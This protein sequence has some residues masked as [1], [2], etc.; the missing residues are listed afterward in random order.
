MKPKEIFRTIESYL[1][2]KP[3]SIPKIREDPKYLR[4][5]G[6]GALII[7]EEGLTIIVKNKKDL[8]TLAEEITHALDYQ[9]SADPKRV[10]YEDRFYGQALSEAL[11]YCTSKI[12]DP[13]RKLIHVKPKLKKHIETRNWERL[14]R[15]YFEKRP[16]VRIWHEIGY[17]LGERLYQYMKKTGDKGLIKS[18][19]IKN[20]QKEKPFEVYKKIL[21]K[22]TR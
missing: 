22:V 13:K 10:Y 20:R 7:D 19:L 6:S 12:V 2:L 18:L 21:E 14:K 5:M 9:N 17:D 3:T 16:S 4:G 1:G 8:S 11:A 15:A